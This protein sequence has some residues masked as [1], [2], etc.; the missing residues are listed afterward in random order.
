MLVWRGRLKGATKW[1]RSDDRRSL[2]AQPTATA[3]GVGAWALAPHSGAYFLFVLDGARRTTS[4]TKVRA[5]APNLPSRAR[6]KHWHTGRTRHA[7]AALS[8]PRLLRLT[9]SLLPAQ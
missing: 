1:R 3:D 5:L 9:I 6:S 7:C 8:L 2:S 4:T